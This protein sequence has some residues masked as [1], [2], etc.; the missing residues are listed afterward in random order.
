MNITHLKLLQM[1]NNLWYQ[2]AI[3]HYPR[4]IFRKCIKMFKYEIE[5][6]DFAFKIKW[7]GEI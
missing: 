5:C 2:L 7:I 1:Y 4:D 3:T 6:K